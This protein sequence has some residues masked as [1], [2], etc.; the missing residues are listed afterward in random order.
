MVQTFLY[1]QDHKRTYDIINIYKLYNVKAENLIP[2][3]IVQ[4]RESR[5]RGQGCLG[6]T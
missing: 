2:V 1:V 3:A 6:P 4:E 5:I